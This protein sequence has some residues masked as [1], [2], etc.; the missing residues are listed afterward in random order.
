MSSQWRRNNMPVEIKTEN[1]AIRRNKPSRPTRYMAHETLYL[2][3]YSTVLDYGCG[4]GDDIDWL[5]DTHKCVVA[6]YDPNFVQWDE[7]I[8]YSA[9]FNVVLCNYVLCVVPNKFE[10]QN[11]IEDAWQHVEDGGTMMVSVRS[12]KSIESARTNS[13]FKHRDGWITSE[14]RHTFQHGY[15]EDELL[16]HLYKLE[17]VGGFEVINNGDHLIAII[18]KTD[19]QG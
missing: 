2:P 15:T 19:T 4:R 13:W 1:T 5:V 9:K 6:G 8:L 12:K 16:S 3:M 10:R 17:D 11:I 18:M 7:K 14:S